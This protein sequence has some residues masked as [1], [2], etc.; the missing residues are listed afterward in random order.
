MAKNENQERRNKMEVN[1][2]LQESD[3]WTTVISPEDLIEAVEEIKK[4]YITQAVNALNLRGWKFRSTYLRDD[5]EV[6]WM[7]KE[8][9][10]N[11]SLPINA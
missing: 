8:L 5:S 4:M 7:Y 9:P 2:R 1:I 3:K 10:D 6:V 11:Q